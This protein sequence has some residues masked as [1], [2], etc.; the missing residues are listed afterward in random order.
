[1]RDLCSATSTR[2]QS[3]LEVAPPKR[4]HTMDEQ[5]SSPDPIQLSKPPNHSDSPVI[6]ATT[7]VPSANAGSEKPAFHIEIPRPPSFQKELYEAVPDTFKDGVDF[8]R[9]DVEAVVGE[10]RDGRTL[11]Y[12]VRFV[13]GLAHK[14]CL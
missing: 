9:D 10:W 4:Q 1:M 12:Y 5:Q 2:V 3:V 13:D 11:Y 7:V 8:V 14:V 6:V